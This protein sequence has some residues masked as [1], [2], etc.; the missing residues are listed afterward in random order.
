[1]RVSYRYHH[2]KDPHGDAGDLA[3]VVVESHAN[4]A[5]TTL[6]RGYYRYYGGADGGLPHGL[7]F[8]LRTESIRRLQSEGYSDLDA[9]P[10]AVLAQFAD[11]HFQYDARAR[12]RR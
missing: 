4:G 6:G 9:V 1:M 12:S 2:A 7:K 11:V 10:D 5:W 3:H 8:A